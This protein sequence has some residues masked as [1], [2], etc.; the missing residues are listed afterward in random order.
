MPDDPVFINN[1]GASQ[2][3]SILKEHT[4]I[5]GYALVEICN[6]GISDIFYATLF[7][8][9]I[10]PGKMGE[11]G[12]H[13]DCQH[14]AVPLLE[15]IYDPVQGQ[16]FRWSDKGKIQGIEKQDA[17]FAAVRGKGNLLNRI[18]GHD[19]LCLKV[20]GLCCYH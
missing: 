4:V 13:G 2:G 14:F 7:D 6:H 20:R 16:N 18:V 12:I 3:Y 9:S 10:F 8:G 1:K 17:V 5:P 15:F 19:R 11:L